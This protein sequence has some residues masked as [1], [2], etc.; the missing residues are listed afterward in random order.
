MTINEIQDKIIEEFSL[1]ED[2]FEKYKYIISQGK[3]LEP[4]KK[5][6]RTEEN[7]I[8]GCQSEVWLKGEIKDNKI[9]FTADSDA[10][11]T[12]GII[13]LLLRVVNNQSPADILSNELYFI[14]SIGL[15][16]NLSPVRGNGLFSIL[17]NIKTYAEKNK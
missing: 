4:F 1:L 9:N 3:S 14:N 8:G 12:K 16:S 2:G 5:E 10:L 6:Y 13:A 17:N 7:L 15:S 11:I